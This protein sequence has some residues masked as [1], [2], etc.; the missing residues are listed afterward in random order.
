MYEGQ[1]VIA[2]HT[3]SR[4]PRAQ[5]WY[6]ATRI[7]EVDGKTWELYSE[8]TISGRNLKETREA[9][10]QA[11]MNLVKGVYTGVPSSKNEMTR[12]K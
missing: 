5:K 10:I 3:H 9:A 2:Y 8:Y 1:W 4:S 6:R 11:G 12:V 7:V